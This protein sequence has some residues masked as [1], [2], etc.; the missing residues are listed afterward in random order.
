MPSRRLLYSETMWRGLLGVLVF[1]AATAALAP[2]AIVGE[3]ARPGRH[4]TL[5]LG[6][7]WSR[8]HL[9]A[10]GVRPRYEGLGAIPSTP[11]IFVSNHQ[12]ILDV[13]AL[14]PA[15]PDTT[16]FV[17]KSSLFRIPLFGWALRA[18]GFVPIDR[19]RK[20]R[21]RGS[22]DR[23]AAMVA[24]GLSV[25][26]FPEG[27]RSRDGKLLPF[28]RGAFRLATRTGA[29][30]VPVAV[31]GSGKVLRPRSIVVRPGTVR[32]RFAEPIDSLPFGEDDVDIL[33]ARVRAAIASG[34]EPD[35]AG[36]S[37]DAPLG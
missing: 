28:K 21:A 34:L 17:A 25:I 14:A 37:G 10:L 18:G 35:E 32:V 1:V 30:I 13:W 7:I 24:S 12:S 3:L 2:A 8:L 4:V 20:D 19:E 31:S 6:R 5:R 16:R 23:A 9:I 36:V 15:L 26:L 29:P 22:I 33:A 27:T 11:C